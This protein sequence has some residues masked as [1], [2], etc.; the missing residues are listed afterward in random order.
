MAID[1]VALLGTVRTLIAQNGRSVTFVRL[2][3][4]P[5]DVNKPWRSSPDPRAVPDATVAVDVVQADPTSLEELGFKAEADEAIDRD[6]LT[7]IAAPPAGGQL[8]D[9]YDEVLDGTERFKITRM[10]VLK[11]AAT[12]MLYIAR[13]RR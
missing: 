12:V 6:E 13:C 7:Y 9:T 1:Y 5:A 8:L 11:P 4:S 10:D 2:D 3:R